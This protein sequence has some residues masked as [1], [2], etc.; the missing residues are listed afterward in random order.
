MGGHVFS[1][2]AARGEVR[3]HL[4]EPIYGVAVSP[5]ELISAGHRREC[6]RTVPLEWQIRRGCRDRGCYPV[7]SVVFRRAARGALKDFRDEG[8]VRNQ[9]ES[10]HVAL[11]ITWQRKG[12]QVLAQRSPHRAF[13]R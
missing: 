13:S 3:G 9:T 1:M 11:A 4:Q 8:L 2:T 5:A 7:S 12:G 10:Y 6:S